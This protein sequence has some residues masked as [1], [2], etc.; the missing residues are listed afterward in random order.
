MEQQLSLIRLAGDVVWQKN[1]R[2]YK[3][4]LTMLILLEK[5]TV[6]IK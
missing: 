6:Q 5:I 2:I 3:I 4:N 1:S